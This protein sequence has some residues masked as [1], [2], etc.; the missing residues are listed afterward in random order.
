[1]NLI[2]Q[3]DSDAIRALA[4]GKQV[5]PGAQ[6]AGFGAQSTSGDSVNLSVALDSVR[7]SFSRSFVR[8]NKAL[9]QFEDAA[10]QLNSLSTIAG[11]LVDL[12]RRAADPTISTVER[13]RLRNRFDSRIREFRS[14]LDAE[15]KD[16]TDLLDKDELADVLQDAGINRNQ[17]SALAQ[18]FARLGGADSQIGLEPQTAEEFSVTETAGSG[19]VVNVATKERNPLA[20]ELTSLSESIA[21]A[22][23]MREL[24]DDLQSDV[25]AMNQVVKELRGAARFALSGFQAADQLGGSVISIE[26]ASELATKLVEGITRIAADPKLAEHSGLD[27]L[28]AK[29]LLG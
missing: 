18:A 25:E 11:E 1:M 16:G 4:G 23:G 20:N 24:Y 19:E 17:A 9:S 10:E 13:D 15:Q 6:T 8:L 28:L 26:R 29:D 21:A 3:L 7:S 27:R 5:R 2:T 14:V 22:A 12:S